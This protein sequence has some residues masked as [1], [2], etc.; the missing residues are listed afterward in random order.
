MKLQLSLDKVNLDEALVIIEET[1]QSVD[2]LEVGTPLALKYGVK[3]ISLL[4]QT[5]PAKEVLADY[6]IIDG[7]QYEASMAFEAG[8]DIVTVLGVASDLTIAG[9]IIAARK[10]KRKVMV[11]LIGV[12]DIRERIPSVEI[13]GVDYMCIHTAMD[14]QNSNENPIAQFMVAKQIATSTRLAVAGGLNINNISAIVPYQPEIV[15][16]GT[17]ITAELDRAKAAADIKQK[18]YE[19]NHASR[20]L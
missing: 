12:M 14:V 19:A 20:L 6:K 13:L 9:T 5:Y 11:D 16:V 7:G 17:G 2:I 4:K 3:A 18:F 8:A 10:Y 15:V 1:K